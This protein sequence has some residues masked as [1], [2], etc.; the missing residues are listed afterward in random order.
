[1]GLDKLAT[2]GLNKFT[3]TRPFDLSSP[4]NNNSSNIIKFIAILEQALTCRLLIHKNICVCV[5]V[6]LMLAF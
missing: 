3:Q 1:M 5:S 2:A 4:F 6:Y